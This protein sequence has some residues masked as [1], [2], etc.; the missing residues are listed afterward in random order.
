MKP[1]EI[2]ELNHKFKSI[3]IEDLMSYI[4]Q[5]Y[6]NV[7]LASSLGAEDQVLTHILAKTTLN[8]DVF[9]LDTGRLHQETYDL[10]D[11][12]SVNYNFKYRIFF[13]IKEDVQDMVSKNGPNHFYNS[14]ENRKECCFIRKVEPLQRALKGYSVWFTGIRRAQS[15][16]RALTPLFEWDD[17]HNLL[18]VNPLVSWSKDDVWSFIRDHNVPYNKLHD[19]GFPSIGC[20]PCTRAVPTGQDDRSG[21]WWWEEDV[22]KECGLHINLN[23]QEDKNDKINN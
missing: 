15:I 22:K 1:T 19:Q 11:K 5:T 2:D 16:N 6:K 7:T 10:M 17:S 14:L 18:K 8:I 23:N 13:P 3:S 20:S 9:V 12:T 21:R 4:T